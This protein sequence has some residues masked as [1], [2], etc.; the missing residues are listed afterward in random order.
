MS[1]AVPLDAQFSRQR[2]FLH[3]PTTFDQQKSKFIIDVSNIVGSD[4]SQVHFSVDPR[5]RQLFLNADQVLVD[6]RV[7]NFLLLSST[8]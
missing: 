3:I 1:F 2:I 5:L 6:V 8:I 7:V 4:F